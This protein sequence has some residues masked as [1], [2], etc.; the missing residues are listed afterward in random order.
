MQI[1]VPSYAS[2]GNFHIMHRPWRTFVDSAER[3][4]TNQVAKLEIGEVCFVRAV[5]P[6]S[7]RRPGAQPRCRAVWGCRAAPGV[8]EAPLAM[9][10][11][12]GLLDTS[13]G[14]HAGCSLHVALGGDLTASMP[15]EHY[16]SSTVHQPCM[17]EVITFGG[18]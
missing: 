17:Q 16:L 7:G 3:P 5:A 4:S 18:R 13:T 10:T 1:W 9:Q 14:Q 2:R 12:S 15:T 6:R 8:S 11:L